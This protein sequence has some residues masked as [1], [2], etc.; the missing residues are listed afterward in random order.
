[1][2]RKSK[3]SSRKI[4]SNKKTNKLNLS[5][6]NIKYKRTKRKRSS[7]KKN[8]YKK[9]K[10]LKKNINMK[11]GDRTV[12]SIRPV[13]EKLT[14]Q[15]YELKEKILSNIFKPAG[16]GYYTSQDSFYFKKKKLP[17]LANFYNYGF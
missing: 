1:M 17:V 7:K 4:K 13:N 14:V 6:K 12:I 5:N 10:T 16:Y 9:R 2:A 15:E 11:G 8:N 3:S